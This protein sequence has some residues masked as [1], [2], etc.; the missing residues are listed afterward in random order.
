ME[1]MKKEVAKNGKGKN[2]DN[3]SAIAIMVNQ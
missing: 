3:N 2:M 1:L